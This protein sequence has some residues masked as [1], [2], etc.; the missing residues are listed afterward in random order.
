MGSQVGPAA[1]WELLPTAV[2]G[3]Y[4][5]LGEAR[6]WWR[7]LLKGWECEGA[8]GRARGR[9]GGAGAQR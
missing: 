8:E 5:R 3:G 7:V 9:E 1:E 6:H 2:F 4:P